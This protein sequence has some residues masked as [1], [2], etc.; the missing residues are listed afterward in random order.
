[1]GPGQGSA[2]ESC[3]VKHVS[4]TAGHWSKGGW[5]TGRRLASFFK[6]LCCPL[7]ELCCKDHQVGLGLEPQDLLYLP[8]PVL[9]L[10]RK[11]GCGR[12]RNTHQ[13]RFKLQG[14]GPQG[15]FQ[16]LLLGDVQ[17][18]TSVGS[19]ILRM[20]HHMTW[21]EAGV[22]LRPQGPAVPLAFVPHPPMRTNTF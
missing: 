15:V 3:A 18:P 11:A 22:T 5:L 19:L 1:M 7:L 9:T 4:S 8:W 20:S 14:D 6:E 2:T 10:T 13:G 21:W 17:D 12:V 16:L